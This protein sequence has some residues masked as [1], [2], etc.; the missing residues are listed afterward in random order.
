[1]KYNDFYSKYYKKLDNSEYY[2]KCKTFDILF[3][4]YIY[5]NQEYKNNNEYL[6]DY[7]INK[8]KKYDSL[9]T[10]KQKYKIDIY[11]L[12]EFYPSFKEK[13]EIEIVKELIDGINEN[14]EYIINI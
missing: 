14:K 5:Y 8:N 2:V 4:K 10:F 7:H 11:F 3:Y 9:H 13:K 6:V 1:M 12:K